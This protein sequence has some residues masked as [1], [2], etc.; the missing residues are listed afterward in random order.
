MSCN[1]PTAGTGRLPSQS[2]SIP[3]GFSNELQQSQRHPGRQPGSG[4]QSLSGFPMSC[5]RLASSSPLPSGSFQ[6]LSGFPMSCNG[7]KTWVSLEPVYVSIPIGFSNELQ[8][9]PP[10]CRLTPG[11][12]S[13]PIGFSNELQRKQGVIGGAGFATFQSLSGFPMSCNLLRLR[14]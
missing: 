8:R 2:V 11:L 9:T 1:C 5:N 10:L 6:S 7:L 13:I 4:F 3:I 12:V 14:E